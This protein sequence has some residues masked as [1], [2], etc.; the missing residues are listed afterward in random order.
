M[1]MVWMMPGNHTLL[2]NYTQGLHRSHELLQN[3]R[4]VSRPLQ[5]EIVGRVNGSFVFYT[6]ST[7]P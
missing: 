2:V 6:N 3:E 5:S 4:C 7:R 1:P